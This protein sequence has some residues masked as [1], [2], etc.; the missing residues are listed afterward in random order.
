MVDPNVTTDKCIKASGVADHISNLL[1][2][3]PNKYNSKLYINQP[4]LS[5]DLSYFLHPWPFVGVVPAF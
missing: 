5:D 2:P 3:N 1:P 4:L